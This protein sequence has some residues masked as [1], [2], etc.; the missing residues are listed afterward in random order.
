MERLGKKVMAR[1]KAGKVEPSGKSLMTRNKAGKLIKV[2]FAEEASNRTNSVGNPRRRERKALREA[3]PACDYERVRA[4]NIAERMELLQ[5][6]DIE[7]GKNSL[8]GDTRSGPSQRAGRST[9]ECG[10]GGKKRCSAEVD[11][12]RGELLTRARTTLARRSTSEWGVARK[13][14]NSVE[15][16]GPLT[17]AKRTLEWGVAKRTL[18]RRSTSEWGVAGKKG[19]SV[20]VGD[21][22]KQ[23]E[24]DDVEEV[25]EGVAMAEGEAV[26]KEV[27]GEEDPLALPS[28]RDAMA[29]GIVVQ[30]AFEAATMRDVEEVEDVGA[31]EEVNVQTVEIRNQSF[32]DSA[33]I[34]KRKIERL[35]HEEE[36]KKAQLQELKAKDLEDIKRS[37]ALAKTEADLL[38]RKKELQKRKMELELMLQGIEEEKS[39]MLK[40]KR[41]IVQRQHERNLKAAD[42]QAEI[43]AGEKIKLVNEEELRQVQA[44]VQAALSFLQPAAPSK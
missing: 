44:E 31:V 28:G 30:E 42:L 27:G 1:I 9:S 11:E 6:L 43:V 10:L 34:A 37:S 38:K 8:A 33:R 7:A 39:E 4:A 40:E 18:A 32:L 26:K 2:K 5:T 16:G 36:V 20:E 41:E 25:A 35:K 29:G 12:K 22:L 3:S 17:R 13:K 15:R 24:E 23:E 21:N 19:C 14:G